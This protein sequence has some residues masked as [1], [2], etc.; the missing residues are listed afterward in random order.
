M[1]TDLLTAR[2]KAA[3][4]ELTA[5]KTA[6]QRGLGL[7]R[8]Y[9]ETVIPDN[10]DGIYDAAVTVTFVEGSAPYPFVTVVGYYDTQNLY[11][12]S[13]AVDELEYQNNGMTAIFSGELTVDSSG[14]WPKKFDV[15]STAPIQSI[16]I[17]WGR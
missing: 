16:T 4:R 17:D 3:K 1:T 11:D 2:L 14:V 13:F 5:L 12:S 8:I 6:H 9:R 7:L 10:Q 15:L